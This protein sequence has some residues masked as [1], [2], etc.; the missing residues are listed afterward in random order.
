L[1]EAATHKEV[2]AIIRDRSTLA[3][4]IRS[5]GLLPVKEARS[6]PVH[7]QIVQ[8]STCCTHPVHWQI[9]QAGLIKLTQSIITAQKS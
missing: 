9:V 3:L 7:W 2:V 4:K 6:H 8:V 5:G 1:V